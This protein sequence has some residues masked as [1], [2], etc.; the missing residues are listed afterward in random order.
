MHSEDHA[1]AYY[2]CS[3]PLPPYEY[4]QVS[5]LP[6]NSFEGASEIQELPDPLLTTPEILSQ[7]LPS[8]LECYPTHN[9][10]V[11]DFPMDTVQGTSV[12]SQFEG[13]DKQMH[14]TMGYAM[15]PTFEPIE[16]PVYLPSRNTE[17]HLY[18]LPGMIRGGHSHNSS[19]I[20]PFTPTLQASPG[21]QSRPGS[22]FS[23]SDVSPHELVS[24]AAS[25]YTTEGQVYQGVQ[26]YPG[27]SSISTPVSAYLPGRP[28]SSTP[29]TDNEPFNTQQYISFSS[30]SSSSFHNLTQYQQPRQE[31]PTSQYSIPLPNMSRPDYEDYRL[32]TWEM[33]NG[34]AWIRQPNQRL[35]ISEDD[36]TNQLLRNNVAHERHHAA[37]HHAEHH[38]DE[39]PPAD[40]A[41]NESNPVQYTP[42]L[43]S[44]CGTKFNG[45]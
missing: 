42:V 27:L 5:E 39:T 31:S 2:D 34:S 8:E 12:S 14:S 18:A 26:D 37:I 10:P 11:Q 7:E 24:H 6:T 3:D 30:R 35:G 17:Q 9:Y 19:P 20:S 22:G 36:H 23:N 41:P 16:T 40:E 45:R 28:D 38:N 29:T 44:D 21:T 43:C 33:P 4:R 15:H 25:H 13:P 1:C 32:G